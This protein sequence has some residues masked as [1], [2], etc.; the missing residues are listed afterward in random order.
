MYLHSLFTGKE[1]RKQTEKTVIPWAVL[2]RSNGCSSRRS[3]GI[4]MIPRGTI[5]KRKAGGERNEK[6]G[7]RAIALPLPAK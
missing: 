4:C 7:G 6:G 5:A 1:N 3:S 2:T